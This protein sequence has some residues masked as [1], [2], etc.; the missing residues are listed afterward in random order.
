MNESDAK[1]L[2]VDDK[3]ENIL[4]LRS[5][6]ELEDVQVFSAL[7]A[8]DALG[9][10]LQ[11]DFAL[12]LLDVQMPVV[13]GFEL[14]KLMRGTTRSRHIPIIF[15]TAATPQNSALF[16]GYEKGAVDFLYKPLN[17]MIVRS[18]VRVF[19]EL[20]QQ[21]KILRKLKEE[22]EDANGA[23][24]RFLA[25]ISHEIRT[26]LAAVLGFAEL[27]THDNLDEE[28]RSAYIDA[29]SRNGKALAK[30]I[31]EVLDLSKI[32]AGKMDLEL[33]PVDL[34]GLLAEIGELFGLVARNKGLNFEL[35]LPEDLPPQVETDGGKLRQIL[36]NLIGNAIKF[37]DN[38][39]VQVRA[40]HTR[41]LLRFEIEDTGC[42]LDEES[43]ARLFQPFTQ[44]D[45]STTRKFGG[46]GLGLV[47]ARHMALLLGG[48][49]WVASTGP[50][51]ATF[52]ATVELVECS[53]LPA[54]APRD[55]VRLENLR[56]LVIDDSPDIL[57]MVEQILRRSG[58]QTVCCSRPEDGVRAALE[59]EFDVV[60]S[61][62]Q[63]PVMDGY[64][65]SSR[66]R[67]GGFNKPI[68][69]LTARAVKEDL[70]RCLALGFSGCVSK[71]INQ[72][73]LLQL[74]SGMQK[75][76]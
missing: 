10:L 2:I 53:S 76:N 71:P 55:R 59:Q 57:N 23:K 74:L 11:H 46:T 48:D 35:R 16:E 33:A 39:K 49:V 31:D 22:A 61:D 43:A 29:I 50:N 66:L 34:P 62:I 40:S 64:E 19:I 67:Q 36:T 4:A 14:A 47:L 70:E 30:L 72:A 25:N 37:T 6:L 3:P 58:A 18:K 44:A 21:K 8:Q 68:V 73:S 28:D 56:V 51:G 75:L 69:A 65:V 13:N 26:P 9:L 54:V 63:M 52:V 1:V 15:V 7:D 41:D 17:P 12:A 5:L 27:L 42:G 24:S 38:G 45:A 20:D 32:E 60:L